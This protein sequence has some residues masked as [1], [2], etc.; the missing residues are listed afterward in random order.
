MSKSKLSFEK[1]FARLEEIA[2]QLES[3]ELSLDDSLKLF[4]EGMTLVKF[5]EARLNDAEGRIQKMIEKSDGTVGIE[6]LEE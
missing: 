2:R 4:E 1:S 6:P 5:C 3:N